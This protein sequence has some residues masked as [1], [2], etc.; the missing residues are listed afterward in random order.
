M[1]GMRG[2]ELVFAACFRAF[3]TRH[4]P[5]WRVAPTSRP[6]PKSTLVVSEVE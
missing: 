5:S 4:L 3:E 1:A 6:F 2:L